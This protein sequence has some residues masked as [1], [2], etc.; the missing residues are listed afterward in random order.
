MDG[1]VRYIDDVKPMIENNLYR[2]RGVDGVEWAVPLYKGN[3]RAKV[4]SYGEDRDFLTGKP[5]LDPKTGKPVLVRHEVIEQV[6]LLGLDDSSLVGALPTSRIFAGK[7]ADL[8]KPDAVIIDNT[9]LAKLFPGDDLSE[10][11]KP[12]GMKARVGEFFGSLLGR[13]WRRSGSAGSQPRRRIARETSTILRR[14]LGRELEMNDHCAIVVGVC[15]A[16]RTFQSNAVVYTT[17]SRAKQFIPQE[18]KILSYVLVKVVGT[19]SDQ[20]TPAQAARVHAADEAELRRSRSLHGSCRGCLA[21]WIPTPGGS[22]AGAKSSARKPPPGSP[23]KPA[24][25]LAPAPEFIW[26]TMSTS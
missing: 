23:R 3:G 18:R 4:N 13:L 15:E 24:C 1:N 26:D 14:F 16:T 25:G 20:L 9:R 6:I 21:S 19:E 5:R 8:R 2:V 22:I 10:E 11:P 17:Y 7:L 12:P